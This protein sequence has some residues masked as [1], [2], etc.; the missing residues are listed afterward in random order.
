MKNITF[1]ADESLIAQARG[2]A[3]MRGT[4]LNEEFRAWIEAYIAGHTDKERFAQARRL[5]DELTVTSSN[6]LA[7]RDEFN[8]R[9]RHM[10]NRLDGNL[11][12][13]E[14]HR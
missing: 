11:Q 3:Q 14:G 7:R 10:L 2:L 9:E 4:T 13:D 1:T 12:I 6:L 5:I 8:D